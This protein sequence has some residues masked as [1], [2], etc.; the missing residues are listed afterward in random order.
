MD[1]SA[2]L[3]SR[4]DSLRNS[5]TIVLDNLRREVWQ[6]RS[7]AQL[8]LE[9]YIWDALGPLIQRLELQRTT[10][11]QLKKDVTAAGGAAPALQQAW[12]QYTKIQQG[13][14]TYLRECLEITGSLAIRNKE[15]DRRIFHIADE[16]IRSCLQISGP[17]AHYYVMVHG[18]ED[19]LSRTRTRIIRLRF[20]EW[21]L[22][23]LP[24]AFHELGHVVI[25]QQLSEENRADYDD[26]RRL[27]EF[28]DRLRT[29][30]TEHYPDLA[31]QGAK[32][33]AETRVRVLLADAFAAYIMGP[34]YAS[35]AIMLRLNPAFPAQRDRPADVAR[36]EVVLGV[37]HA[38]NARAEIPKPYTDVIKALQEAWQSAV[39]QAADAVE[40]D[41]PASAW[42]QS[43]A[44]EFVETVA[45]AF[46]YN[47]A[48]Y[49]DG[50]WTTAQQWAAAWQEQRKKN[51]DLNV[52]KPEGKLRDVLNAVWL[53][54]L[55]RP[56]EDHK[57]VAKVGQQL[58]SEIIEEPKR[59]QAGA[60]TGS[61]AT[62]GRS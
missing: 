45:P 15:L 10:L 7:D 48:I 12:T 19:T 40:L 61:R 37:L 60:V 4:L 8:L 51:A 43:L 52:P 1:P 58:C 28:R 2:V 30:L 17:D 9:E 18:V 46:I 44:A 32:T 35:A 33:W 5:L 6:P 26:T 25:L 55:R 34:A 20:S 27:T 42:L 31:E 13:S 39:T 50:G 22:W 36:A 21:T 62:P 29:W 24:L 23:D 59:L 57:E 11:D 16:L 49:P 14:Q 54:R 3:V 38:L 47:R 53:Y 41:Q 56:L